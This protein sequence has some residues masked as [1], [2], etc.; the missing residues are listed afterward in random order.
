MSDPKFDAVRDKAYPSGDDLRACVLTEDREKRARQARKTPHLTDELVCALVNALD[1]SRARIQG[2]LE[3]NNRLTME[4]RE[5]TAAALAAR[6]TL[7][8]VESERDAAL[9]LAGDME[10]IHH[11]DIRNRVELEGLL[12]TTRS[13]RDDWKGHV[14]EL[15]QK[16]AK[17]RATNTPP[18]ET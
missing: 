13:E 17:L 8:T 10:V 1:E 7:E 14:L 12:V 2:L 18:S 5:A 9:S 15:K 6:R 16:L 4:R 3:D 11:Q